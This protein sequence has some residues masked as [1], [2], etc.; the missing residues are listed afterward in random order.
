MALKRCSLYLFLLFA[1]PLSQFH[2]LLS[3][4]EGKEEK[5]GEGKGEVG[6][7]SGMGNWEGEGEQKKE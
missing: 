6:R 3:H 1:V 7:G 4:S 2:S 5:E